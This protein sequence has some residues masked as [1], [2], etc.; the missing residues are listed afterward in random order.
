MENEL[1]RGKTE[2]RKSSYDAGTV[3]DKVWVRW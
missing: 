1:E 2:G 3:V